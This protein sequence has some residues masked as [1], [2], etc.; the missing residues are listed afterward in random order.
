MTSILEHLAA[1]DL[2]SAHSM[3]GLEKNL[4]ERQV[5]ELDRRGEITWIGNEYVHACPLHRTYFED[6]IRV[7]KLEHRRVTSNVRIVADEQIGISGYASKEDFARAQM[8][9]HLQE[10]DW[11][12]ES[13]QMREHFAEET[14]GDEN[15]RNG[16]GVIRQPIPHPE[17]LSLPELSYLRTGRLPMEPRVFKPSAAL[18]SPVEN[19][20]MPEYD[21]AI[22]AAFHTLLALGDWDDSLRYAQLKEWDNLTACYERLRYNTVQYAIGKK[23]EL[24]RLYREAGTEDEIPITQ[25]ERLVKQIEQLRT[26]SLYFSRKFKVAKKLREEAVAASGIAFGPYVSIEDRAKRS[27]QAWAQRK[28]ARNA[29]LDRL[30]GM[31]DEEYRALLNSGALNYKPR[32]DGVDAEDG[33]NNRVSLGYDE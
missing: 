15:P 24:E 17:P 29:E 20:S 16:D 19:L 13:E 11:I 14:S 22:A 32:H 27:A 12:R 10:R 30:I 23:K 8:R 6:L 7:Q 4:T 2:K 1:K 5:D 33:T 18:E 21:K 9:S 3:V 31:S 28:R 25:S 26:Q